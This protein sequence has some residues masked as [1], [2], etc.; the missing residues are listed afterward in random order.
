MPPAGAAAEATAGHAAPPA[1]GFVALSRFTVA[2]GEAM[3]RQVKE[4]FRLG[5]V[6]A[7]EGFVRMDVLSPLDAPAEIWLITHWTDEASFEAWH[8]SHHYKEAHQGIPK[9][10]KLVR[11]SFELRYFDV[12]SH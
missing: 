12:V 4:A 9:G 3:T 2:N 6:D 1:A 10:L 8:R 5:L 11:G 7:A